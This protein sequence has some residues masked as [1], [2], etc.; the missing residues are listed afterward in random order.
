MR[1]TSIRSQSVPKFVAKQ[2]FLGFKVILRGD[3]H[4]GECGGDMWQ[5]ALNSFDCEDFVERDGNLFAFETNMLPSMLD[6]SFVCFSQFFWIH[7][8][9]VDGQNRL[10]AIFFPAMISLAESSQ[11]NMTLKRWP[12]GY[13]RFSMFSPDDIHRHVRLKV[14]KVLILFVANCWLGE[15]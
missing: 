7:G 2:V 14:H 15:S 11:K 5:T 12:D 4:T 10:M 9:C 3:F 8:T 1:S 6:A 13:C